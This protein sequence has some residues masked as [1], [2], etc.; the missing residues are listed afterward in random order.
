VLLIALGLV[1]TAGLFAVHALSTPGIIRGATDMNRLN[2]ARI[3]LGQPPIGVGVHTGEVVLGTIGT[4]QRADFTAIGDTVN[5]AARLQEAA[6][7]LGLDVALS[8][9]TAAHLREAGFVL[10][11]RGPVSLRGKAAPVKVYALR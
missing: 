10:I 1:S 5:T 11:D 4:E 7:D 8:E 6:R 2:E 3:G 9:Q